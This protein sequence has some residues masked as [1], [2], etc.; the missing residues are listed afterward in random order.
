MRTNRR[1]DLIFGD[2]FNDISIPY[3]L[4]TREFIELQK[5][6]LLPGGALAANVI[7]NVP[8]G[9]FLPSYLGTIESVFG[10][11]NAIVLAERESYARD[12]QS[13]LVVVAGNLGFPLSESAVRVPRRDIDDALQRGRWTILT[14][15][16]APVDNLV[17]P[18][19][20]ERIRYHRR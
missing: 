4:T 5:D 20:A 2:A 6:H 19:F 3:H 13:T 18:L 15:D 8:R 17:A 7:D 11:G 16:Y 9:D 1:Y 12:I 10:R 14:D